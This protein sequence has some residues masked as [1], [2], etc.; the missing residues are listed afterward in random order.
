MTA[1]APEREAGVLILGGG[2]SGLALAAWLARAGIEVTV[3]DKNP[4]PGGVIASLSKD[5]F[6]FERGPNTVLNKFPSFDELIQWAGLEREVIRVPLATQAR[7]VWLGGRLNR[8]PTGPLAFLKTPLL[9]VG[10]KLALFREPFV[11][12]RMEDETVADFVRRRL[13]PAWVRNLITPMVSGIWAGDPE[14]LSIAG[15]FPVMKE[16]E[17]EGGSITR[18]A[19]KRIMAKRRAAREAGPAYRRHVKTLVSFPEG[20]VRLPRALA[21]RLGPRYLGNTEVL[22]IE[23]PTEAGRGWRVQAR[24]AGE[25]AQWLAGRLVVITSDARHAAATVAPFDRE[26]AAV[27]EGFPYNRLSVVSL[28]LRASQARLPEGF[29]FLVPRGEGLRI[30]GAIVNSNFLPGRAPEGCAALTVFVGGE[31]DPAAYDLDDDSLAGLVRRDL[32]RAIGWQGEPLAVHIERWPRAIPQY[33]MLHAGRVRQIEAAEARWP[34]L[35]LAGNW[36]GGVSIGDRIEYAL[37]LSRRIAPQ[38]R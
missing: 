26:A 18:G 13:G 10:G 32:R 6:L 12:Q 29:G 36:R 25:E 21:E 38:N 19:L 9:P 31:L 33:D 37:D 27:L 11:A 5:G 4:E 1:D 24:R 30:L 35:H 20:L 3:L 34:G 22:G 14:K 2:I 15:A 16:M 7:H 8:V 17:R 23:P 28:G